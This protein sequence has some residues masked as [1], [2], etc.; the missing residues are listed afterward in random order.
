MACNIGINQFFGASP[1]IK[2]LNSDI[3]AID[4][5]NT[6]ERLIG[7]VKIPYQQV[8]RGRIILKAGQV[9]YLMNHLGLGDNAT[10]VAII[11]TYD[12]QSVNEEDNYLE[13]YYVDNTNTI[14]YMDQLMILTGNST[15][16]IPQL[17][18]NNP[19][20]TYSVTLDI[21]VA[22]IDD[23]YTFFQN[24]SSQSG[25]SFYN[26]QCNATV[27]NI[28]TFVANESV[29]VYSN[30]TSPNPWVYL[31]LQDISSIHITGQIVVIDENTVG[32]LYLEFI[33]TGDAKQAFS[34]LNYVS[35]NA[36]I[37]IQ[38]LNPQIDIL[39]PV[40]YFYQNVGN[41]ASGSYIEF[42]GA[43]D[44]AYDT[45]FG[46]TFSTSMSLGIYGS[47]SNGN[48]YITKETLN[49]LL[50]ATVSDNRDGVMILSDSNFLLSD[51]NAAPLTYITASGTYSLGFIVSD[52][53]GNIID[54]NTKITLSITT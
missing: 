32:K 46:L 3:V 49:D 50:I 30:D 42:N 20:T 51:N 1:Y 43:S 12:I 34:L 52:F 7:N 53:A 8:L 19:N 45:S 2:F 10:F 11:A 14:R 40:A 22:N 13:F 35:N 24:T 48:L 23:T 16:R 39:P 41:T 25:L 4:G 33:S 31:V 5:P 9:G 21:M 6:I 17:Y 54:P 18:F 27:N 28:Q 29:V 38:S 36:N 37:T 26:L 15:H 47:V 44:Q